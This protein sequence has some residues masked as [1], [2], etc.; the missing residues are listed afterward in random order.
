MGPPRLI[1]APP[2]TIRPWSLDDLD[3]MAKAVTE[4]VDHLRPWMA[5][6]ADEPL[7]RD[8]R[9]EIVARFLR[10]WESGEEYLYAI[11]D[12]DAAVGGTGL[13]M[14]LGPGA[15]EI[16]YWIHPRWTGQGLATLA[17]GVMTDVAFQLPGL[18]RVE[19]HHDKANV[20]SRRIP[21]KLG[22]TFL[23]EWPDEIEA[24]AESGIECR[25]RVR[26]ADWITGRARW[27]SAPS[28]DPHHHP[29][30]EH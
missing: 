20:A 4:S 9:A 5:W 6:V 29:G 21:E 3:E 12:G 10:Q 11:F 23:G 30:R 7:S 18:E 15:V 14:R 24:P 28:S 19:I 25:W 26:R 1:D 13:H 27:E 8:A 17:A 22:Y 2:L 16:G